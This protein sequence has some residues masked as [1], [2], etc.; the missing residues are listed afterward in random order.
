[1]AFYSFDYVMPAINACCALTLCLIYTVYET[2]PVLRHELHN[3]MFC[4]LGDP[5]QTPQTIIDQKEKKEMSKKTFLR[6]E[7]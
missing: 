1:M 4:H 2:V 5:G 6:T 3:S 7:K